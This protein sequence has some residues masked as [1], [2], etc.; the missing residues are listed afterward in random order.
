MFVLPYR[1]VIK[2]TGTDTK[3]FLQGIITN[4]INLATD[5][6][7]LYTL[8]LTP[9]GKVLYDFFILAKNDGY[10]IDIPAEYFDEVIK[11]FNMY[12]L[13]S[14]IKIEILNNFKVVASKWPAVDGLFKDPRSNE[15]DYYRG[16]VQKDE[17]EIKKDLLQKYHIERVALG[18]PEL[19]IDFAP[20]ERFALELNMDKLNSIN[21]NKGCYIGQEVTARSTYRGIIRK[22]LYVLVFKTSPQF[23]QRG[24]EVLFGEEFI[25]YVMQPF[26]KFCLAILYNEKAKELL[27]NNQNLNFNGV[28][29]TIKMNVN[30]LYA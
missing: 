17:L 18:I 4:D 16:F 13:R 29:A 30:K 24:D 5:N 12:K 26:D 7:L 15:L 22:G 9:Q 28:E 2:M 8:I 3:S 19:S 6:G 20:Q 21:Y 10:L 1:S 14:D 11:K 23:V 25:G 27:A